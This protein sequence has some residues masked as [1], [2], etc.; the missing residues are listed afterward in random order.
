MVDD[1]ERR[2]ML[3]ISVVFGM[4]IGVPVMLV[5]NCTDTCT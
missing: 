1:F 2:K 3:W 5:S 4:M